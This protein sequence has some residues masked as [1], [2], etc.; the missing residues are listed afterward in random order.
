MREWGLTKETAELVVPTS[1]G[2]PPILGLHLK[3]L[4][5][6]LNKTNFSLLHNFLSP[7]LTTIVITTNAFVHPGGTVEPWD[8]LPNKVV[9]N[10][11]SAIKAFPSS[12]H[13]L[14]IQMGVGLETRLTEEISAFIL[15]CGESLQE[16]NTNLVLSTQAIVHLMKLPNLRIWIVKQGP[17]QVTD[18]IHHGVPDEAISLLPSLEVLGLRDKAALEWL[19]LFGATNNT[20]WIMPFMTGGSLPALTYH[21][22]LP[23][24]SSLLSKF[25]PLTNL[26]DVFFGMEC[27]MQP[28][29]SEFTNQD[30]ERLATALPKLEALTLGTWPC[31]SNTCPTTVRSLLFLSIHCTK[32]KYLNIHFRTANLQADVSDLF[33]YACPQGLFS[34]PKCPLEALVMGETFRALDLTGRDALFLVGILMIFP[35]LV[36]FVTGSPIG[37]RVEVMVKDFGAVGES[38]TAVAENMTRVLNEVREQAENGVPVP[39]A[40]ST[41]LPFG[42]TR[43]YGSVRTLID[44]AHRMNLAV[45]SVRRSHWSEERIDKGFNGR[46]T[47]RRLREYL[48]KLFRVVSL[49]VCPFP[50]C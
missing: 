6:W 18:L 30:V 15:G 7:Y 5:W 17:P 37:A 3:E 9:P 47:G 28:C 36:K 21:N 46:R 20:P 14:C 19:S 34:R 48:S 45:L 42:L 25:L 44:I 39:S 11:R 1:V 38:L 8:G 40:V 24:N 23:I 4:N 43:E 22:P 13:C 50:T 27:F 31:N 49:H 16:F 12:L 35:S 32:L 29:V 26:I 33:S 2:S 41:C 10:M